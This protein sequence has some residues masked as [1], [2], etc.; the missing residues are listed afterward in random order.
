MVSAKQ[1]GIICVTQAKLIIDL[2]YYSANCA[3]FA[4][5]ANTIIVYVNISLF[6]ARCK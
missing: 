4:I 5:L 2:R 3:I 6:L 1:I